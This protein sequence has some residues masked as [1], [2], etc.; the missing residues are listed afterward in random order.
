MA[1]DGRNI[2]RKGSDGSRKILRVVLIIAAFAVVIF[3]GLRKR[4]TRL[5]AFAKCLSTKQVKMYGAYWCPH[6]AEQKEMFSSSFRYVSYVEC[7]L[8]GSRDESQAC[9]D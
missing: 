3:L 5:D 6:C 2:A 7:G 8:P 9:K 1:K 4:G